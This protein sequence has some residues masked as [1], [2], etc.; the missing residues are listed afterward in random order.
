MA[1]AVVLDG[2]GRR[3]GAVDAL[4]DVHLSLGAGLVHALVGQN[5]AGKST[6]LGLLAGRLA[7]TAGR[8][9]VHGEPWP[10]TITPEMARRAGVAAIYQ[11]LTIVPAMSALDNAFLGSLASRRGLV[12][13]RTLRRRF[14][15]L[16][17]RLGVAIDPNARAGELSIAQQ[18]MLEIM[19]ALSVDCRVLLLDEPTSALSHAEREALFAVMRDLRSRGVTSIFVSHHLDEVMEISDTVTAFRDGRL[20]A[21]G[22]TA[23]WTKTSMIEAMLGSELEALSEADAVRPRGRRAWRE[24]VLRAEGL[25]SRDG[26]RDATIEVGRGEVV[27]LGGLMGSGRTSLIDALNGSGSGVTGRVWLTGEEIGAPRTPAHARALGICTVPEDRRTSGLFPALSSREN[28]VLGDLSSC[29]RLGFLH[30]PSLRARSAALAAEY[31]VDARFLDR[32]AGS[33]SG[34]NQ[35][36]LLLARWS[37]ESTRVLLADEPTRGIDIGAK[38]TVIRT[39]RRLADA[40]LGIVFVSSDL[41]ELAAVSDRAY[42]LRDGFV[43]AHL[44]GTEPISESAILAAAFSSVAAA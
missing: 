32:P 33:L 31:G 37:L 18:Q 8:I 1:T 20:V 43:V 41:E 44:D 26:V 9:A 10:A 19:R 30:G 27:G 2:V 29:S 6:C 3:F 4:A 13:T 36:K 12:D 11:E 14:G 17:E 16:C 40:G 42:V 38:A 15:E 5:G 35:Q 22:P 34:G 39:L 7:P 28:I 23:E 24:P 25:S 21:N